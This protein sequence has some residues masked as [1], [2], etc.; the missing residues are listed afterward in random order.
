MGSRNSGRKEKKEAEE[1]LDGQCQGRPGHLNE[2]NT[3]LTRIG[4][5]TRNREVWRSLVSASSSALSTLMEKRI[6]ENAGNGDRG[7]G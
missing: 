5:A 1:D 3:D 6:E 4:E 2:K 7:D